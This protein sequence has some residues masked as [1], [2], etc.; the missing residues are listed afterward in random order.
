MNNSSEVHTINNDI[1][2]TTEQQWGVGQLV[3]GGTVTLA[4]HVL[5]LGANNVTTLNST[6]SIQ[7]NG[8]AGINGF[9][10]MYVD[11]GQIVDESEYGL[12]FLKRRHAYREKRWIGLYATQSVWFG[13]GF[14][15][16]VDGDGG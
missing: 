15:R 13:P 7:V 12:Y 3:I 16:L 10:D 2:V 6:G 4:D 8:V 1:V 5:T 9:G 11:S 14:P